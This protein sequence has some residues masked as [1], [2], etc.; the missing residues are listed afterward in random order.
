M[1]GQDLVDE[2]IMRIPALDSCKA[3]IWEAVLAII[4]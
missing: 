2:L 1:T 4:D 3:E